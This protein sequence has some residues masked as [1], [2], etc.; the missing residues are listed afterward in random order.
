[1]VP[2]LIDPPPSKEAT[3]FNNSYHRT[4]FYLA[5]QMQLKRVEGRWFFS[6]QEQVDAFNQRVSR[7]MIATK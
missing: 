3:E 5:Q 1:M 7:A 6:S 2:N 4:V